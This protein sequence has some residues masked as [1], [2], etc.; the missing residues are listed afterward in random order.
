VKR[1]SRRKNSGFAARILVLVSGL[2]MAGCGSSALSRPTKPFYYQAEEAQRPCSASTFLP[3]PEA[4]ELL[5][6]PPPANWHTVLDRPGAMFSNSEDVE[7][8]LHAGTSSKV[9]LQPIVFHVHAHQRPPGMVFA[10]NCPWRRP[11]YPVT[12]PTFVE[13]QGKASVHYPQPRISGEVRFPWTVTLHKP[14]TLYIYTESP[15]CHCTWT[16]AIPWRSGSKRGTIDLRP[17]KGEFRITYSGG[18][19]SHFAGFE[20]WE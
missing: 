7:V 17:D 6:G 9:T 5:E 2:L 8:R 15:N 18:V 1:D 3:E 20:E 4:R 12:R 16:A 10:A 13:E 19:P 11:Q 14:T